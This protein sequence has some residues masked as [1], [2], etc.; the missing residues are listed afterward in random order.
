MG[1]IKEAR[2]VAVSCIHTPHYREEV[3]TWLLDNLSNEAPTHFVLLGDLFD[4][5]AVSVHPTE[6]EHTLEDEYAAGHEY[7]KSIMEVLP[8]ATELVWIHGNHDDNILAKDPRRSPRGLRSLL[9]WN[10]HEELGPLFREWKQIPYSK[11]KEGVYRLGQV[12]FYHGFDAGVNADEL[13]SLQMANILGGHAHRLFVKGHTHRPTAGVVQCMKT[14][15]VKLPWYYVNVGTL[16]PLNPYYM[17]R[18]DSS[19]WGAAM[20]RGV[21]SLSEPRRPSCSDWSVEVENYDD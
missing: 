7:L 21:A 11:S 1:E 14:K 5:E 12:C 9:S 13:E 17:N 16:G 3:R 2:F 4:A 10:R 19:G 18:K 8:K 15:R 20:A 6:Y